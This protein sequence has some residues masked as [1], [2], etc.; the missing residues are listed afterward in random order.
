[1]KTGLK[2]ALLTLASIVFGGLTLVF[3]AVSNFY[4]GEG[5]H[6][7]DTTGF[8]AFENAT[9]FMKAMLVIT[10]IFVG[11]VVL[12]GIVKLLTDGNIISNKTVT[13]IVNFIF[14]I[15]VLGLVV[16]AVL[17]CISV[18]ARCA[19]TTI[20]SG[21]LDDWFG[22]G[23]VETF[24]PTIWALVLMSIFGALSFLSGLFSLSSNGKKKKK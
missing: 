3:F 10:C 17:Y 16:S 15:S 8:D 23:D 20:D 9:D 1:M 24:K 5:E 18:G 12:F 19:D 4:V 2:K 22:I 11:L 14:T 6:T 21:I 13:K 7:I